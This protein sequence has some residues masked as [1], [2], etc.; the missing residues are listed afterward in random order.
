MPGKINIHSTDIG[1]VSVMNRLITD[2]NHGPRRKNFYGRR[3]GTDPT[4]TDSETDTDAETSTFLR[5]RYSRSSSRKD[6]NL[7]R[8][9]PLEASTLTLGSTTTPTNGDKHE[10]GQ[11]NGNSSSSAVP[12]SSSGANTANNSSVAPSSSSDGSCLK[13]GLGDSDVAGNSGSRTNDKFVAAEM[14]LVRL[15]EDMKTQIGWN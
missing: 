4:N 11:T 6:D 10:H 9:L 3:A 14:K 2:M 13:P 15:G 12:S 8:S 5:K 7:T 1:S